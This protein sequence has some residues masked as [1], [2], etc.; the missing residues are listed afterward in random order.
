MLVQYQAIKRKKDLLKSLHNDAEGLCEIIEDLEVYMG[1]TKTQISG[2]DLF[3]ALDNLQNCLESLKEMETMVQN[4]E[5]NLKGYV[6]S[7][8]TSKKQEPVEAQETKEPPKQKDLDTLVDA[9]QKLSKLKE[10]L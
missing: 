8:F 2:G 7:V 5:E 6:D 10:Q 4:L 9:I 1:R 3:Q